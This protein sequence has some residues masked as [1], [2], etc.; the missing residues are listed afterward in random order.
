MQTLGKARRVRIYT[1]ED[2]R[3]EG[4]PLHRAVVDLLRAEHAQGA[5]VYRGIEGFGSAGQLHDGSLDD[6]VARL[7]VVVEWVDSPE[8]V[9]RLLPRVLDLVRHG[10]VTV[11]E[12]ELL[13]VSPHRVRELH[14]KATVADVMRREVV[15]VGPATPIR[16]VVELMLGKTYRSL[17]VVDGGRLVGIVTNSDLVQR[18]GLDVRLDLLQSLERPEVQEALERLSALGRTAGEAMTRGPV[19]VSPGTPLLEAA[20]T[21]ARRRLKRLPVVDAGGRLVGLVSRLDLLR[22]AAAGMPA[23]VAEA[24]D[25]GLSRDEPLARVMRRDAPV[26]HPETPLPEVFQAVIATRLHR[27]FVVDDEGR[28]VG[29]VSD[30]ELLERLAP[31]LRPTALQALVRRLPFTRPREEPTRGRTAS[32]VMST[33]FARVEEGALLS[34]AIGRM[35]HEGQKVVAVTDAAGRLVGMVDRADLLRGLVLP[36]G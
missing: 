3:W 6:L 25:L 5:T 19:A 10:L 13:R 23:A 14:P 35:L 22:V 15:T 36:S 32:D 21:M 18:G 24:C 12:P 1:S 11:D 30:A 29:L 4:K 33:T 28:V 2:D 27:A 7:P 31:A 8:A 9:D 17:P 20:E 26:V 34:D 16:Q